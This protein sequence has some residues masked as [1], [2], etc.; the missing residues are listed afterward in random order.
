MARWE[1]LSHERRCQFSGCRENGIYRA[2]VARDNLKEY[3]WFCLDHVRAYN[4]SWNFYAGMSEG[5]IE[6]RRRHDIVWERPS[7]P[8][9]RFGEPRNG[10][11]DPYGPRVHDSFGF[12]SQ[13]SEGPARARPRT[14]EQKALAILDLAEPVTF[15]DIKARYK[16]LAKKLH[17][18]S[19]GGD[20]GAEERLKSVNLAYAALK[21]SFA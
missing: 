17:P 18:D 13:G 4:L 10:P 20:T 9:G 8:F 14:A 1:P 12:F 2:P 19:N 6:Y 7:W 15:E 3:Y 11:G 5:E 16:A 21:I